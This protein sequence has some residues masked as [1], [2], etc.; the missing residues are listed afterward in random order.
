ME[1]DESQQFNKTA[2][3]FKNTVQSVALHTLPTAR[4]PAVHPNT[5]IPH[6]QLTSLNRWVSAADLGG[7]AFQGCAD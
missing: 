4:S 6:T 7:K 3:L 1:W 2:E 5:E